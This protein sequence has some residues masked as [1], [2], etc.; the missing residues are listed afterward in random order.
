MEDKQL[1]AFGVHLSE[2]QKRKDVHRIGK[3][4][5]DADG[6]IGYYQHDDEFCVSFLF[7]TENDAKIGRNIVTQLGFNPSNNFADCSMPMDE[8]ER[9]IALKNKRRK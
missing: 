9:I 5:K 1:V 2:L 3:A 6:F 8:Y 4:I 7:E